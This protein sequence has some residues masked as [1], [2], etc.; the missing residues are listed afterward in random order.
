MSLAM[1][2]VL[3]L[4]VVLACLAGMWWYGRRIGQ[5]AGWVAGYNTAIESCHRALKIFQPPQDGVHAPY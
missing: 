2:R 5:T 4:L 3:L 1:R